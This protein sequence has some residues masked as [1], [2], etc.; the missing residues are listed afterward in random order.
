MPQNKMFDFNPFEN[1]A[2]C[3]TLDA[4]SIENRL[5]HVSLFGS[6]NITKDKKGLENALILKGVLDSIVE[7]LECEELPDEI[8][9][10]YDEKT[11]P[12]PFIEQDS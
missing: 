1:E 4:M 7:K 12:N 8:E 9:K 11:V 2:E 10:N 3:I 6:L 5:L